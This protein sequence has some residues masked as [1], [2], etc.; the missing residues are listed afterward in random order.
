M[1]NHLEIYSTTQFLDPKHAKLN[2]NSDFGHVRTYSRLH[3]LRTQ[4]KIYGTYSP[5]DTTKRNS[6]NEAEKKLGVSKNEKRNSKN[7]AEEKL[8]VSK[9]T[10]NESKHE[11]EKRSHHPES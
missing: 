10:K 8:G 6:K 2:Q 4:G 9:K 1:Q 5:G 7:E 3:K 11:N